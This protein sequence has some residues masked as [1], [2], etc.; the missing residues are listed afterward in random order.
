MPPRHKMEAA[1]RAR[2]GKA[3][4]RAMAMSENSGSKSA[5]PRREAH[6]PSQ[7]TIDLTH[8]DDSDDAPD[9]RREASE[10][11]CTPESFSSDEE[12][13]WQGGVNHIP[14]DSEW[15]VAESN[16]TSDSG[17]DEGSELEELEGAELLNSLQRE[18]EMVD[19]LVPA[20]GRTPTA[21][22]LLDPRKL[23]AKDWKKAESNRHL[24]YNGLSGR[25]QRRK[26][27]QAREKAE[28]DAQ[29]RKS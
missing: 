6:I 8:S 9:D 18:M 28:S 12:C 20:A 29:L 3:R 5:L 10:P 15:E 2:A 1:A 22:E 25:T 26:E 13:S 7:V 21:Y 24:G 17:S 4:K 16:S 19:S 23:T 11:T 14:T 27:Q